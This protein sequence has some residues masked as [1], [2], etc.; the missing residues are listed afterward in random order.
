MTD[1]I[2]G[3]GFLPYDLANDATHCKECG[4][5]KLSRLA[6]LDGYATPFRQRHFPPRAELTGCGTCDAAI[7]EAAQR[8]RCPGRPLLAGMA[9]GEAWTCPECRAVWSVDIT[10]VVTEHRDWRC[11][12][13]EST[14][15]PSGSGGAGGQSV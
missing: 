1:Q 10:P 5:P 6:Y 8:H 14:A 12:P 15:G 9:A 4:Q 7:I 11:S 3:Q 13:H 2:P